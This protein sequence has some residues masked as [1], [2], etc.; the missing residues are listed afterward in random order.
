MRDSEVVLI[1][2]KGH[3]SNCDNCLK[4][5]V[6]CSKLAVFAISTDRTVEIVTIKLSWTAYAD[7]EE[8]PVG[9]LPLPPP[10]IS[11]EFL[12]KIYKKNTEMNIQMPFCGPLFPELGSRPP[13]SKLSGSTPGTDLIPWRR[14]AHYHPCCVSAVGWCAYIRKTVKRSY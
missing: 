5:G 14:T 3:T 11:G 1:E 9:P 12:Q 13:L 8:G 6:A 2:E 7:L 10:L 4:D